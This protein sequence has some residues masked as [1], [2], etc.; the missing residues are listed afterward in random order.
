MYAARHDADIYNP[1]KPQNTVEGALPLLVVIV[2]LATA[3][4]SAQ[5]A[6]WIA[7]GAL[8]LLSVYLFFRREW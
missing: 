4:I 2:V 7:V 3:L 8:V 1:M 5:V 6:F